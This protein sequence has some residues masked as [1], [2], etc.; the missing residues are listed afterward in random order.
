MQPG[1]TFLI[2]P[3]DHSIDVKSC[4]FMWKSKCG[5]H[6]CAGIES[7]SRDNRQSA[8]ADVHHLAWYLSLAIYMDKDWDS[9]WAAKISPVISNDQTQ[10]SLQD[11]SDQLLV[12]WL[13]N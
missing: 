5:F 6:R 2:T 12:Q 1:T 4:G 9:D 3:T 13:R 8:L 10:G 11:A 7:Y